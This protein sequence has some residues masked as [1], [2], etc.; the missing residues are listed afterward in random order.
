MRVQ[1]PAQHALA[2]LTRL[3][4]KDNEEAYVC[5]IDIAKAYPSMPHPAITYALQAIGT[6]QHL[7]EMIRDIYHR[8]TLQYG[9][10]QYS[11]E[12]GVKEGCPL[13]PSLFVLVYKAFHQT[14]ATEIPELGIYVYMDDIVANNLTQ[15][16]AAMNRISELSH[17]LGFHVNPGKD[18]TVPLGDETTKCTSDMEWTSHQGMVTR[19]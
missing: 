11:L 16:K 1:P 13:S 17:L 5:L 15:L 6:P 7:V 18:K 9:C 4:E 2:M 8:S 3:H 14:L 19:V 12:R 10:F